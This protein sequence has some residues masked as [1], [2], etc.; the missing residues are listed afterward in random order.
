MKI[1]PAIDIKEGNVVRLYKGDFDQKTVYS[2]DPV[3]M[4]KTLEDLGAKYL[5][6]VDLDGAL[7]S[8]ENINVIKNIIENTKLLVELGGGIRDLDTAK[9]WLDLGVNRIII[10][11]MAVNNINFVKEL[12]KLYGAEKIVVGV[13][14]LNGNV[15]INGWKT[16]TA[17]TALDFCNNLKTIGVKYIVYTDISKD[18]TLSGP[19]LEETKKLIDETNMLFTVSGGISS[20]DDVAGAY[21]I[22]ADSCIIGK[23]YY[24]GAIN[25][26]SAIERFEK[27]C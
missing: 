26:K 2:N 15:A 10:G 18:G 5:H 22:G 11:S 6:V 17:L 12:I 16:I 14:A 4:A 24:D 20:I 3:M 21:R 1:Y 25:L 8:L 27:L 23:A 13:D 7:G 9:K 19:N